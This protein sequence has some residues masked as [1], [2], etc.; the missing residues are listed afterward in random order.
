MESVEGGGG[1]G[2]GVK[3]VLRVSLMW[4]KIVMADESVV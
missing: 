1:G 4:W 3:G 2:G